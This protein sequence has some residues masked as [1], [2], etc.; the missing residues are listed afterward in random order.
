VISNTNIASYQ[1]NPVLDLRLE[2]IA[3]VIECI[4]AIIVVTK[5]IECIS[6]IESE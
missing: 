3:Y 2:K 1:L 4:S 5:S 6:G